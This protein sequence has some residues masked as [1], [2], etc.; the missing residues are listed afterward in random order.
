M[1]KQY[2][3]IYTETGLEALDLKLFC[4]DN[5]LKFEEVYNEEAITIIES[6]LKGSDEE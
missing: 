4:K 5:D 3:I 2:F 6:L 1:P